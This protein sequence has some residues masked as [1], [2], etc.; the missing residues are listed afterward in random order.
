[1]KLKETWKEITKKRYKIFKGYKVD[2][3]IFNI[4]F[5][6][7]LGFLI[8]VAWSYNFDL[9]YYNCGGGMYEGNKC[10][11]PFYK[12]VSWKNLE[13]LEPGEY[14]KKPG[15]L[16]YSTFV[17]AFGGLILML[18]LNHFLFNRK[19]NFKKEFKL[20]ELNITEVDLKEGEN[21]GI[22]NKKFNQ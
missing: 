21:E 20:P 15:V 9:D 13:F 3:F 8:Y 6:L 4:G 12:P 14:G 19:F 5:F 17:V 11:N 18:L 22:E 2:R 7:I 1:M 16:F 10:L